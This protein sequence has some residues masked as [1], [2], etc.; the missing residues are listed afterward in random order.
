MNLYLVISESLSY[1]VWEDWFN[2]VGHKETY[3]IAELV[4]AEKS[5]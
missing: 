3:R 2:E 5:S 4:V 1:I